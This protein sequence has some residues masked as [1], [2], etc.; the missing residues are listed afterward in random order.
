MDGTANVGLAALREATPVL[1]AEARQRASEFE[2]Q[3][4]LP[5]D[6]VAKLKAAGVCRML[7][8]PSQGGFGSSLRDWLDVI[9]ALAESDGSTGWACAHGAACTAILANVADQRF[10][11]EAMADADMSIAWS[12]LPRVKSAEFV[13]GG[14]RITGGMGVLDRVHGHDFPRRNVRQARHA[15]QRQT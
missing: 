15:D 8:S 2:E 7:V 11:A 4:Q 1:A 3:R 13:P 14:M 12:D 10:V 9:T 5:E 6:Y